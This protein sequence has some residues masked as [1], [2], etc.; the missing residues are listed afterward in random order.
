MRKPKIGLLPFY[1][2]L[3]DRASPGLR[4]GAEEF[5]RLIAGE[6]SG[7]GL[8]VSAAPLCRVREEF[9]REAERFRGAG[10]DA[11]VTLHAAYSPSLESAEILAGLELPLVI[12][13]TT[14]DASFGPGTESA[15]IS[16]NHGIHGVQDLCNMLG[17]LGR[18][19][20]LESGH[21]KESDVLD[22]VGGWARAAVLA[23]AFRGSRVGRL[24]EPFPGMGDFL[25]E[26]GPMKETLGVETVVFDP[27]EHRLEMPPAGSPAVAGEL[28]RDRE[29]F[30]CSRIP[31]ES[32]LLAIRC[33]LALRRWLE[34]ER[35]SAFSFNFLA[36]CRETGLPSVPFLEAGKAMARGLGYAGEGDTLTAALVGAL[37][38]GGSDCGFTEMFCPDWRGGTVFLSHMGEV[39]PKLLDGPGVLLEK[40]FPYAE[41]APPVFAAGRLRDGPA[42]LVNLAPAGENR[43]RLVTAPVTVTGAGAPDAME[44]A[45]RGWARP[46]K[47]L[48][49]FLT[50]YS[51]AGGTHHLALVAGE[52]SGEIT[53]FGILMGWET[54]EI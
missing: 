31:E 16:F 23:S 43:F 42:T 26:P 15:R 40:K 37:G 8:S 20:R 39:N 11:V 22:R 36:A 13:N 38:A 53:R 19:F 21:W 14:P 28:A 1:L 4:P 29:A 5:V 3:Y 50:A 54:R 44:S 52:R 33:G 10:L 46:R 7:R 6:L 27:R 32:H 47:D 51:E 12:L 2:E 41:C 30:D 24:G 9:A 17:R 18:S 49:A 34:E 48:A 35:L 25:V 45:V